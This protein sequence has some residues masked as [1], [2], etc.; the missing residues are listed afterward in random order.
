MLFVYTHKITPRLKY[1]FTH[2]SKNYLKTSVK[3]TTVIEEFISHDSLKIS[4]KTTF[5][6]GVIFKSHDLL[7][8]EGITDVEINV[9]NWDGVKLFSLLEIKV[10][11]L[12]I[13]L[14]QHFI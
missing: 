13:F 11:F 14:Q 7:F 3:F 4:Y 1:V 2:I 10:K 12:T 9:N 6:E 8:E 5:R